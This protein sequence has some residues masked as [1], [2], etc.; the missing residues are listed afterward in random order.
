MKKAA[1]LS[2][3]LVAVQL[4]VV[5]IAEAQQPNQRYRVGYLSIRN[6]IARSEDAFRKRMY[7]LGYIEGKNLVIDW[8]FAKGNTSLFQKFRPT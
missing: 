4:A 6:K 2:I 7:E 1:V 3:L 5:V 8:R